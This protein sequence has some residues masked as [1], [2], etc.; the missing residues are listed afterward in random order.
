MNKGGSSGIQ[1]GQAITFRIPSDTP[2]HI[3]KQ[4]QKLK[5]TEKRNFS[6]K[7]AEFVT[8][9]VSDSFVKDK[10]SITIPI[11]Q[12]LS[13]AQRDWIKHEHSEA[14]LGSIVYQ[15]LADP[16]RA[17]SLLASF[18]SKSLDIDEALYLQEVPSARLDSDPEHEEDF[19]ANQGLDDF[20]WEKALQETAASSEKEEKE[21]TADDL[22]GGFLEKMNK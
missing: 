4:L 18:T 20:D 1:R 22:I 9:G 21:E 7:I 8:Q 11:P 2:E 3:I 12:K 17:A 5:E 15:I 16:V 14:L 19:D 13:K 6:S 10:E